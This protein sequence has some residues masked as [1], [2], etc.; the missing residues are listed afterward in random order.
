MVV[1]IERVSLSIPGLE[2]QAAV[3][4]ARIKSTIIEQV[5]FQID[6]ITLY[7]ESKVTLN[8]IS[9][10]SRKFLPFVIN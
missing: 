1:T 3:L 5:D 8:C 10:S 2:L 9:N 4:G 6:I 7:S